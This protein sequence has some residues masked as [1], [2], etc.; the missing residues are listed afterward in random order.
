MALTK[1]RQANKKARR[2]QKRKTVRGETR[3]QRDRL[4]V[5]QRRT[6]K[7]IAQGRKEFHAK[8]RAEKAYIE[9][10]EGEISA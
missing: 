1:I 5:R 7:L 4:A 3:L 10:L 9:G 2:E 8:R 6:R